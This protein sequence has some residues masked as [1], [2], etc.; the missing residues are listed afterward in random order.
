M[1]IEK[2]WSDILRLKNLIALATSDGAISYEEKTFLRSAAIKCGISDDALNEMLEKHNCTLSIPEG[3]EEKEELLIDILD[4]AIIDNYLTQDE[5]KMCCLIAGKLGFS[6]IELKM[7]LGL[8]FV[9]TIGGSA[10]V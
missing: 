7:I 9:G 6:E 3:E 4:L 1:S 5:Y 10:E 8:S 2:N